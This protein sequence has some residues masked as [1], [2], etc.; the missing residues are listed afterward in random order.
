MVQY[1]SIKIDK[2]D[3]I[4]GGP[5]QK[6]S[7]RIFVAY[8]FK[9]PKSEAFR[10][11]L[12]VEIK[13]T[14]AL[15]DIFLTDGHVPDGTHWPSEIRKRVSTARLIVADVTSLSPE[16]VFECG[17]AWGFNKNIIPVV[18]DVKKLK[19]LPEWLTD[20]QCGFFS[21]SKYIRE[22]LD[23][24]AEYLLKPSSVKNRPP[25][26]KPIP[27]KIVLLKG[28][29]EFESYYDNIISTS[30]KFDMDLYKEDSI[31]TLDKVDKSL[32]NEVSR[33]SLLICSLNHSYSDSFVHF[34]SGVVA[35]KPTAGESSTKLNRRIL[36][37]IPDNIN[38]E[39]IISKSAHKFPTLVSIISF[40]K[41]TNELL[42]YGKIYKNYLGNL[43]KKQLG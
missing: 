30:T 19:Q 9:D 38:A 42:N 1:S 11:R 25:T 17:L 27:G 14:D 3:L 28:A 40:K 43:S 10:E 33:A 24:I 6:I 5:Q 20:L 4:S 34:A 16:V 31:P 23:S 41:L 32:I 22:I 29:A 2:S 18:E 36:I 26:P 12:K 8:R 21:T 7:P 15:N 13:N 39:D 37:C 35:S